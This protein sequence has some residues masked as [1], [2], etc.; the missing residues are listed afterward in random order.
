ME[1]VQ[2]LT[3]LIIRVSQHC[4]LANVSRV[5]ASYCFTIFYPQSRL[6]K[7]CVCVCVCVRACVHYNT[8]LMKMKQYIS[9]TSSGVLSESDRCSFFCLM[10]V[11]VFVS[12]IPH[13]TYPNT[14][15][16]NNRVNLRLCN[17]ECTLCNIVLAKMMPIKSLLMYLCLPSHNRNAPLINISHLNTNYEHLPWKVELIHVLIKQ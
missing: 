2:S 14:D 12:D 17:S 11:F 8:W 10:F 13:E 1:S 9:R 5:P 15:C 3:F 4:W 16:G 7:V 6:D